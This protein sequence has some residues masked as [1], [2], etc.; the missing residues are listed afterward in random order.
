MIE[1]ELELLT[2]DNFSLNILSFCMKIISWD[3]VRLFGGFK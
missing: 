1:R 3:F 2:I